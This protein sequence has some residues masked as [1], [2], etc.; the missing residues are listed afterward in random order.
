MDHV[1]VS[2]GVTGVIC[3]NGSLWNSPSGSNEW[4]ESAVG[5][6]VALGG[7][8]GRWIA[9]VESSDCEG[10]SLVEFDE[11]SV[12][13]LA[14]APTETETDA[15]LNMSGNALWLWVGDQ[16]MISTDLGRSFN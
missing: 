8:D 9:A 5:N 14:C 7:S 13:S 2:A 1:A 3:G 4:T 10:L 6:A 16:V 12:E 11:D 15:V